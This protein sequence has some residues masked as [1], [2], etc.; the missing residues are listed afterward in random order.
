M[1]DFERRGMNYAIWVW[2]STWEPW[3]AWGSK[4]MNY[5][6]GPDPNNYTEVPNAIMNEIQAAWARN[7]LRPSQFRQP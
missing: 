4:A 6:F 1:N 5:L 3:R 2:D 7:I